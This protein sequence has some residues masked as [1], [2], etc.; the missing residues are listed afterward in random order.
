MSNS[1]I[2]IAGAAGAIGLPLSKMLISL[3]DEVIGTT[4]QT[5]RAKL[6][7]G[8]GVIPEIVDVYDHHAVANVL[9]K[10]QPEIVIHQLTDLP[11]GLPK[12]LMDEG[13]K[14]NNNIRLV[15]TKNLIDGLSGIPVK[16]LI[17]QSIAFVYAEGKLPHQES[18]L[19]A[20]A[21][22]EKFEK[23]VLESPFD[24]TIL[25]YGQFYGERTGIEK[26]ET[27]CRVN[28]IAAAKAT[29]LSLKK[30]NERV[31]NICEDSEYADNKK[32]ISETKWDPTDLTI[33]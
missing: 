10:Y 24:A 13:R 15:G 31:Y 22:L 1:R 7:S 28:V 14:K 11:Y 19:L 9:K 5:D 8:I 16:R 21:D 20:S 17:V 30:M 26:V 18:D 29:V 3:G 6:L 23:L 2:F 27:A 12:N 4:R 25:R 32:F 33:F